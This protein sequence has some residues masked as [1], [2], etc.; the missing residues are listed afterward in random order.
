MNDRIPDQAL[1]VCLGPEGHYP[2]YPVA[3][4]LHTLRVFTMPGIRGDLRLHLRIV[5]ARMG[6]PCIGVFRTPAKDLQTPIGRIAV[7]N[8]QESIITFHPEEIALVYGAYPSD[9]NARQI[10]A[11]PD[12]QGGPLYE[13]RLDGLPPKEAQWLQT[14]WDTTWRPTKHAGG[15]KRGVST[16][17]DFL[18]RLV[19]IAQGHVTEYDNQIDADAAARTVGISYSTLNRRLTEKLLEW[20]DVEIAA[21]FGSL[22]EGLDYLDSLYQKRRRERRDHERNEGAANAHHH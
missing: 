15:R 18:K 1:Q 14:V 17:P 12:L 5:I 21:S 4:P 22:R 7:L 3:S 11:Y 8:P 10:I 20:S 6:E 2:P 19:K 13:Y 9:P 16:H